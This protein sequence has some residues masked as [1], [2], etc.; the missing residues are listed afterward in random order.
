MAIQTEQDKPIDPDAIRII[1][2]KLPFDLQERVHTFP[3]LHALRDFYPDAEFHFIT[4]KKNIE[5]LNLLPFTAFYHEFDD[6][7]IRTVFDVH[8]FCAH[9]VIGNVDLF[10]NL[11]NSFVDACIGIALR[12]KRRLGFGD[13]WKGMLLTEKINRPVGHHLSDDFNALYTHHTQKEVS[14]RLRVSSREL[15]LAKAEWEDSSY[16]AINLYP[17]RESLIADEWRELAALFEGQHIIFFTSDEI[18][19]VLSHVELFMKQLPTHNHYSFA[20]TNNWIE[21]G[22]LFAHARGVITYEG[23]AAAVAAYTGAQTI[24]LYDREDPQRVGPFYFLSDVMVCGV[25]DPTIIQTLKP[26]S[27]AGLVRKVFDMA[28]IYTR[29]ID[30]FKLT[31]KKTS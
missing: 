5:V 23:A 29:A 26:G 19:K 13:G 4:P 21:L 22:K 3:F 15:P 28:E 18:E 9:M 6:G 24:A 16:I 20:K 14:A 11:S 30:F 12:A 2:V 1:A 8:R 27:N 31:I 17:L 25:N 7:E 10:I